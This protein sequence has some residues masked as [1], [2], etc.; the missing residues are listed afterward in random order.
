MSTGARFNPPPDWP[1]EPGWTPPPEWVPDR[2]WP[3]APAGWQF[4]VEDSRDD[5]AGE[6]D[7]EAQASGVGRESSGRRKLALAGVAVIM[8][9]LLVAG[10]VAVVSWLRGSTAV[11]RPEGMLPGTYPTAPEVAWSVAVDD[12]GAVRGGPDPALSSPVFGAAYYAAVGA[13]VADD[14]VVVNAMPDRFDPDGAQRLAVSLADGETE[15]T[16]PASGRDG[17]ARELVG[18]LLPCKSA[19]GYGTTS[20]LDLIDITTGEVRSSATVPFYLNMVA[21]DGDSVYTAGFVQDE[22]LVVAKGSPTDPLADWKVAI[23]GGAC[24]A[25][26]GG[27]SYQFQVRYGIVSGF[28]GGGA[29]IALHSADGSAIFDH[30]VANV[31]VL[32]PSVIAASRCAHGGEVDDWITEVADDTG[33]VLFT[34]DERLVDHKLDVQAG[35]PSVLVTEGGTGLDAST[36]ETLWHAAGWQDVWT[37]AVVG[38][39]V[40]TQSGQSDG[41]EARALDSGAE[42]WRSSP[43]LFDGYLLTDGANLISEA[44]GELH[45]RSVADGDLLWSM[46]LPG[47]SD[48][49]GVVLLETGQGILFASPT[50]IGLLRP[51]GPP[52][53]P[54]TSG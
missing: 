33:R 32:A 13:V 48:N 24:D 10:T 25:A 51:T 1:V 49:G 11:A 31:S 40:V 15:W 12:I 47:L 39:T 30:P 43:A 52:S 36:G 29:E 26:G 21:S 9:V 14:H 37:A 19:D 50:H 42:L 38:N 22:G 6:D 34:S 16:A 17:C 44:D 46:R 41:V 5:T 4:W 45:A 8:A 27:D 2:S 54:P 3:P 20:R 28:Q 35:P 18:D 53:R 7:E 23:P